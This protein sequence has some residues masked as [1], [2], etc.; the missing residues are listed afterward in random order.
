[1][2]KRNWSTLKKDD[3]LYLLVPYKD[4][5]NK[6]SYRYEESHVINVH[7]YACGTNIRFKYTNNDGKRQ[8]VELRVNKLKYDNLTVSA[9]KE[10]GWARDN[11]FKFG[12][13]LVS[14]NKYNLEVILKSIIENTIKIE[15]EKI[16]EMKSFIKHLQE[17]YD[18]IKIN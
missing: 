7:E 10:T 3:R 8:R 11:D 18:N 12:D 5:A 14:F 17:L 6:I 15:E 13:I 4:E 2:N 1:M 9:T 16:R